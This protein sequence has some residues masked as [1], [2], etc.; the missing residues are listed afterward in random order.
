[1]KN[2]MSFKT[3]M[4]SFST[5]SLLLSRLDPLDESVNYY[6]KARLVSPPQAPDPEEGRQGERVRQR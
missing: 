4:S 5:F 2:K 3:E 6:F 1:M